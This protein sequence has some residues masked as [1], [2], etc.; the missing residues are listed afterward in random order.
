MRKT[1]WAAAVSFASI[2]ALGATGM[3]RTNPPAAQQQGKSV[4]AKD[5]LQRKPFTADMVVTTGKAERQTFH[6]KI[7]AGEHALRMDIQAQPG[8]EST[9]IIRFDKKV[10]WVLIPNQ[11]MYMEMPLSHDTGMMSALR[12]SETQ[13]TIRDL[14]AE[15]VGAYDCEKYSVHWQRQGHESNGLVWIGRS[16]QAKGFIVRAEDGRTGATSEYRNI[17][18][19][20]PPA[21][22]FEVPAGYRKMQ[23]FGQ[24]GGFSKPHK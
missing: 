20:E 19:G 1:R 14:G 8:L 15:R 22:L 3:A 18:P 12:D 2:L 4:A 7:Y 6:G 11:H 16:G 24:P 10:V 21:S 17:Q 23:A 5:V 9:N 13:Y